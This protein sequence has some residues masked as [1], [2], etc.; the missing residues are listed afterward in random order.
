MEENQYKYMFDSEDQHW[1][2]VGN[3]ENFVEI[4][5]GEN[6]L[7]NGIKVLDAGCGTGRWL[8]KLASITEK[9]QLS[10]QGNVVT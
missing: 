6:I 10:I 1:W 8:Q 7:R 5:R 9:L 4:L 2:Y 3:H